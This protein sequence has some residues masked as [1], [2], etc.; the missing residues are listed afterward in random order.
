MDKATALWLIERTI[1]QHFNSDSELKL[2]NQWFDFYLKKFG[3]VQGAFDKALSNSF[4]NQAKIS[5]FKGK[6]WRAG[7]RV[8]SFSDTE[9]II[10]VLGSEFDALKLPINRYPQDYPR[11]N[12]LRFNAYFSDCDN[13]N[14]VEIHSFEP[15]NF[16]GKP[17]GFIKF[18]KQ[19]KVKLGLIKRT[20]RKA[21]SEGKSFVKKIYQQDELQAKKEK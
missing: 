4:N 15:P 2:C 5:A 20:R 19:I 21:N 12:G 9:I 14:E 11:R 6:F 1:K 16:G 7:A 3:D 18:K 8:I 17:K 10:E 13:P